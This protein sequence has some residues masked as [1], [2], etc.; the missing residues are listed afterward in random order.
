MDKQYPKPTECT[1]LLGN[2][3]DSEAMTSP[4]TGSDKFVRRQNVCVEGNARHARVPANG[5]R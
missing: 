1:I 3:R 4:S 2:R 5:I